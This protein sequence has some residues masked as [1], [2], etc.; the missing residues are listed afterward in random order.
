MAVSK[1]TVGSTIAVQS[2]PAAVP[3]P[4]IGPLPDASTVRGAVPVRP[5]QDDALFVRESIG[6]AT[7]E[8]RLDIEVPDESIALTG[9]RNRSGVEFGLSVDRPVVLASLDVLSRFADDE[10]I[11]KSIDQNLTLVEFESELLKS[12]YDFV[13]EKVKASNE[14]V[15]QGL[16]DALASEDDKLK[17]ALDQLAEIAVGADRVSRELDFIRP[18]NSFR[19]RVDSTLNGYNFRFDESRPSVDSLVSTSARE[20]SS[21]TIARLKNDVDSIPLTRAENDLINKLRVDGS[22]LSD[23][24]N[25]SRYE[26]KSYDSLD[27]LEK[28]IVCCKV[29]SRIMATTFSEAKFPDGFGSIRLPVAIGS[30]GT[31]SSFLFE[32]NDANLSGSFLQEGGLGSRISLGGL[33]NAASNLLA[34]ET[35]AVAADS[36]S[37]DKSKKNN[38]FDSIILKILQSD[39][40]TSIRQ[41]DSAKAYF[42]EAKDFLKYRRAVGFQN[43]ACSPQDILLAIF[44]ELVDSFPT[45]TAA[46]SA[47]SSINFEEM[48]DAIVMSLGCRKPGA[49]TGI[50]GLYRSVI[51]ASILDPEYKFGESDPEVFDSVTETKVKTDAGDGEKTVKTNSGSK[52]KGKGQVSNTA[53]STEAF[54]SPLNERGTIPPLS[55]SFVR[56][57]L[58]KMEEKGLAGDTTILAD[59]F[60]FETLRNKGV[61]GHVAYDGF[62]A[63]RLPTNANSV[64]SAIVPATVSVDDTLVASYELRF[65]LESLKNYGLPSERATVKSA[66]SRVY[67]RVLQSFR[68]SYGVDSINEE[69]YRL[70][71]SSLPKKVIFDL[72][73]EGVSNCLVWALNPAVSVNTEDPEDGG[74]LT[75]LFSGNLSKFEVLTDD[76]STSS[77]SV[78]ESVRLLLLLKQLSAATG[79]FTEFAFS[80][81]SNNRFYEIINLSYSSPE[82]SS[83]SRVMLKSEKLDSSYLKR[84]TSL[85]SSF[86]NLT[87]EYRE[88]ARDLAT[89]DSVCDVIDASVSSLLRLQQ[90]SASLRES[91]ASFAREQKSDVFKC[92]SLPSVTAALLKRDARVVNDAKGFDNSR[93]RNR[94]SLDVSAARWFF[95]NYPIENYERSRLMFFGLPQGF[96]SALVRQA[97][98][99]D[100]N[101]LIADEAIAPNAAPKYFEAA[102]TARPVQLSNSTYE[103]ELGR[104]HPFIHLEQ[105]EK[106]QIADSVEA[107]RSRF[108]LKFFVQG[109]WINLDPSSSPDR[110]AI[111]TA[112]GLSSSDVTSLIDYHVKSSILASVACVMAGIAIDSDKLGTFRKAMSRADANKVLQIFLTDAASTILRGSMAA[113]DFLNQNSDGFIESIPF[114]RLAGSAPDLTNP[115]DHGLLMKFLDTRAFNAATLSRE[116]LL[117]SAFERVYCTILDNKKFPATERLAKTLNINQLTIKAVR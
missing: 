16:Q 77:L 83:L 70:S 10:T 39:S 87:M 31:A 95:K 41:L 66:L 63:A 58:R 4:P 80:S 105:H 79:S 111:Q 9:C 43:E 90:K 48:A 89:L 51:L 6:S 114:S 81:A 92:M 5:V 32:S 44:Q 96:T 115:S 59:I 117:P 61:I 52:S 53:A 50:T 7:L 18:E 57:Y 73:L 45:Y 1:V 99:L 56:D 104:F 76:T 54:Y 102:V 67:N 21:S 62:T 25:S 65:I 71:A 112:L 103:I 106:L 110:A 23:Q 19:T 20:T 12:D 13:M 75:Y 74:Y 113:T 35:V 38:N 93:A 68:S 88:I 15:V 101:F 86:P 8:G 28:S 91:L 47:D 42:R 64:V 33:P 55:K 94:P 17:I 26:G 84:F 11:K 98:T 22:A 49:D 29:L 109:K 46:L 34:G 85:V 82:N 30:A 69:E 72:L 100:E 2:L 14:G 27:H 60:L 37:P 40:S 24:S 116:V 78:Y 107:L 36:F 3:V 108:A 97:R